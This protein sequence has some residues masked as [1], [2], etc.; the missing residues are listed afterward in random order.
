MQAAVWIFQIRGVTYKGGWKKG[1]RH[2]YGELS[3]KDGSTYKGSWQ[4]GKKHG[5]GT[6]VYSSGNVYEGGWK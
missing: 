6:L 1:L 5:L 2:G 4:N 3:Y